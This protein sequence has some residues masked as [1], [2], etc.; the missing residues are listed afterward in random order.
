MSERSSEESVARC[1][2]TWGT[3]YYDE[4]YGPGAA[5]P[6]VHRDLLLRLLDEH[7][8]RTLL[9]AGCGPASFLR[10]VNP[11]RIDFQGF[12]LTPEMVAEGQRILSDNHVAP[13]RLW[14]GSVLDPAAFHAPNRPAA[15]LC[16]AVIC[17]GVL[18]HI[19][20]MHQESVLRNLHAVVRPGG[21]AI[22]EARN[23]LFSLFSLNRY[24]YQLFTE[25]LI[26][27]DALKR[28]APERA[29]AIDRALESLKP[30]FA[31]DKPPV[32]KGKAGE[33]G[34]DEIISRSHNPL[35]FKEQMAA[36]G[37]TDVRC[38]FY[39]YHCVPPLVAPEIAD[40]FLRESV[41]MEDPLDWRGHF[42]ASAFLCVGRKRD[43]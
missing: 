9:D 28:K 27:A 37:F 39:H 29:P 16:D 42:M 7:G 43:S 19:P 11:E 17:V 32:R 12:D 30:H 1:Y 41:A 13:D 21:I 31:M 22:V 35:V 40:L 4:Y 15:A 5:Y 38:M 23:E 3:A 26:D 6:P 33:P 8:V 25:R 10:H 24:S 34:Y 14:Q 18:P 2:S 20:D 36:V